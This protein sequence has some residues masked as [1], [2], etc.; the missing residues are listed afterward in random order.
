M[1]LWALLRDTWWQTR[2]KVVFLILPILLALVSLSL[3][4]LISFEGTGGDEELAV[5][6]AGEDFT[7]TLVSSWTNQERFARDARRAFREIQDE[8]REDRQ[9]LRE[10]GDRSEAEREAEREAQVER[11]RAR[12]AR[13]L[14]E[15]GISP[16]GAAV[17][18]LESW[19]AQGFLFTLAMMFFIFGAATI[20]PDTLAAGTVD[21]F[22][23]K[24]LD[25]L[26]FYL[27]KYLGGLLIIAANVAIFLGLS[28]AILTAKSGHANWNYLAGGL[29]VLFAF[30]VLNAIIHLFGVLLRSSVFSILMGYL[31]YSVV[32]TAVESLHGLVKVGMLELPGWAE[33]LV[34]VA[35]Y[36]LPNF[37][38]MKASAGSM[39]M[40]VSIVDWTPLWTSGLFGLVML[41]LG[42]WIFSRK[43]Y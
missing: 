10:A 12:N 17:S 26:R 14:A 6:I 38:S 31:L 3:I 41:A 29:M 23:S 24:P 1:K 2:F 4:F 21:L 20:M 30:A 28:F 32:D 36:V 9:R 33:S 40:G 15:A 37:G 34:N 7:D 43:E 5:R 27:G 25:R 11:R 16:A 18:T 22:L 8:G 13:F 19:F 35:W 42:Y 39:I